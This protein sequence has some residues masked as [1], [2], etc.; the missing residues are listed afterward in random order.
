MAKVM[1]NSGSCS[2]VPCVRKT[3][4]ASD[5][6]ASP[7]SP[8][9]SR[10]FRTTANTK[11]SAPFT[12]PMTSHQVV[13]PQVD[14]GARRWMAAL[15]SDTLRQWYIST[16]VSSQNLSTQQKQRNQKAGNG[17][18]TQPQYLWPGMPKLCRCPS[19][20]SKSSHATHLELTWQIR[21]KCRNLQHHR[22][23]WHANMTSH[24]MSQQVLPI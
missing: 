11:S 21:L 24:G 10:D 23:G 16:S 7:N 15:L 2:V 14:L 6:S 20:P 19:S 8:D 12:S 18:I 1:M 17:N 3:L 9:T 22:P 4:S 13:S 5:V